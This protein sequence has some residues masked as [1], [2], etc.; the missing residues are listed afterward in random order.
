MD[1][2]QLSDESVLMQELYEHQPGDEV[3]FSILR[4]NE[5][6]EVSVILQ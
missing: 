5:T 6:M 2:V 3:H 1:T 4:N